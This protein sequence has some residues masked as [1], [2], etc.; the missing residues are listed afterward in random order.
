MSLTLTEE[1][2]RSPTLPSNNVIHEHQSTLADDIAPDVAYC[3]VSG[4]GNAFQEA[5]AASTVAKLRSKP[6]VAV[7]EY[8][9]VRRTPRSVPS[10]S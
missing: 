2:H 8:Y 5:K 1:R 9:A 3:R 7:F 4:A 10:Y 6:W